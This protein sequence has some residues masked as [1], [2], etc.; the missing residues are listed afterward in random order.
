MKYGLAT[1]NLNCFYAINFAK[2]SEKIIDFQP[3]LI[4]FPICNE[5]LVNRESIVGSAFNAFRVS[6]GGL[7]VC[8]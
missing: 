5:V 2:F 1:Q 3:F 7:V 8:R 6:K 4:V